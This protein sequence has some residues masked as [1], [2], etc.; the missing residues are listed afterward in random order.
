MAPPSPTAIE[1]KP[2]PNCPRNVKFTLKCFSSSSSPRK[3]RASY[4]HLRK[5]PSCHHFLATL[6]SNIPLKTCQSPEAWCHGQLKLILKAGDPSQPCNMRP[7][8]LTSTFGKVFHKILASCLAKYSD[9]I[10]SSIAPCRK[11]F[12]QGSMAPLNIPSPSQPFLTNGKHHNLPF[13]LTYLD[14][15]STFDSVSH[16]FILDMPKYIQLPVP[17]ISYTSNIYSKLSAAVETKRWFTP[18]S[19]A[20]KSSR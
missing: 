11:A 8:A 2:F 17:L 14:F 7:V 5:M 4:F 1:F 18:T 16:N 19:S 9:L 15:S 12:Y 3:D 6:Y 10:R 20:H 13:N